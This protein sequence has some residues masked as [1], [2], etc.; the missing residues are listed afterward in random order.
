MFFRSHCSCVNSVQVHY[1]YLFLI[2]FIS[3]T[4][5]ATLS[6]HKNGRSLGVAFRLTSSALK[7]QALYP[8]VLCK[9]CSVSVN[10]DPDT[11]WHPF[12]A[13]FCT[14]A[15]LP[16]GQRTRASLP[17]ASKSECEVGKCVRKW[18][19]HTS[20]WI[21]I[22][23]D[24]KYFLSHSPL[25]SICQVLM[26]VGMPGS[27]KTHW[28]QAHMLQNPRKRYNLL[29]TNSILNC[30]RVRK[31]IKII[32]SEIRPAHT[33]HKKWHIIIFSLLM[34]SYRSLLEP[35][36]EIWCCKRPLSAS[37]TWSR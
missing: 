21:L 34:F 37:V 22:L 29:S 19:K 33:N 30:M 16:P 11:P 25:F 7:G 4:G 12:P 13:G 5:E 8:H 6:F 28:A 3:E 36:T 20:G 2:Q 14:L 1:L 17:T 26:M 32:V 31:S 27:G 35:I 15:V 24:I 18:T 9:N 10:L 23:W